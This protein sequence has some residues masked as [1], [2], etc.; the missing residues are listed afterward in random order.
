LS[1]LL[2]VSAQHDVPY[3]HWQVEVYINNFIDK[4]VPPENIHVIFSLHNGAIKPSKG[5]RRLKLKYENIH[6]YVDEREKTHYIPSIKPFLISKWLKEE[7]KRGELFFLHD[8]DILLT[9][10]PDFSNLLENETIYMSDTIGYLGYGYLNECAKRY[11]QKHTSLQ[12]N[13]L[14]DEMS[15]V[16]GIHPETIR[17]N[18]KNSGGAQYVF[19]K[20]DWKLWDKIYKDSTNLYDMLLNFQKK[21]PI[22]PGEIQFWT[23]E[24]WSILWNMWYAGYK[25]KVVDELNFSWAT[26][27]IQKYESNPIFHLAG[28]TERDKNTRFFKADFINKNPLELLKENINFFDYVDKNN[29]THKYIENMKSL[30]KKQQG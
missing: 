1:D 7:P 8:S 29:A 11:E 18:Q 24:M 5:A 4:G 26:D 17:F 28:I 27:D 14:I 22:S 3:F 13:Q 16:I 30:L 20:Q 25:T 15:Q 12:E 6:F 23:A 9:R 10:V 2:F 21:Y 19:K